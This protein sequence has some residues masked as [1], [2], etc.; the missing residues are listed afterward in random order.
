M[1]SSARRQKQYVCVCGIAAFSTTEKSPDLWSTLEVYQSLELLLLLYCCVQTNLVVSY[2]YSKLCSLPETRMVA[3]FYTWRLFHRP[4][5]CGGKHCTIIPILTSPYRTTNSP[6]GDVN[7]TWM[8]ILKPTYL[9]TGST[10]N[11]LQWI[12]VLKNWGLNCQKSKTV[13]EESS[14]GLVTTNL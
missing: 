11:S 2:L 3:S 9:L 6:W 14:A 5:G 8:V 13:C 1:A 10:N 7:V 12:F 4:C